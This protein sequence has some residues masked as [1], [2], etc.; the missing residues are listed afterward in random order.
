M[1][2]VAVA[3][4]LL[5]SSV[6]LATLA[7]CGQVTCDEDHPAVASARSI[8]PSEWARLFSEAETVAR[9]DADGTGIVEMKSRLSARFEISPLALRMF[10][11]HASI[12]LAGCYDHGVRLVMHGLNSPQRRIELTWGEGPTSGSQ[13][14]WPGKNETSAK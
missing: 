2:I 8:A 6:C 11:G 5:L 3:V 1:R 4:R 14:L 9:A 13:V 7:A 12:K 10:P